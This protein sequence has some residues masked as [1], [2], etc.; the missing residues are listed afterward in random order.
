MRCV[1][2]N[3]DN[4]TVDLQPTKVTPR[5]RCV[6]WNQYSTYSENIPISVTPRMRCV[7]WNCSGNSPHMSNNC[8]TSYEVCG[9]KYKWRLD[10]LKNRTRH[11]SYEVCGLKCYHRLSPLLLYIVT[12]RMRCVDW[13]N[14][15]I[16]PSNTTP[17]SHTSYEVCGLKSSL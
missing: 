16:Q 17:E 10:Y 5:M 6:D 4:M 14:W 7:D 15:L 3:L 11:T 12:P 1:D 13:N 2:W 9:L 8:H